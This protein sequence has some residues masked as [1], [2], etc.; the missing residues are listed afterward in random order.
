MPK[1]MRSI[2][3][4]SLLAFA[5]VMSLAAGAHARNA[6]DLVLYRFA[7]GS[8]AAQPE[9]GLI[10]DAAGN[11][12]GTTSAGGGIG[13]GGSGCGTV[14]QLSPQ[15]GGGWI[16]TILHTFQGGT[17]GADPDAP[18]VADADGNLYGS[19]SLGGS[20]NCGSG[21]GCGTVFR[22]TLRKGAWTE[23][24][25]YSF[26][27]KSR[28]S[29]GANSRGPEIV[30]P[31]VWAP[32][33]VAFGNDGN[34]YGF[35]SL[36]GRCD[37][38]GFLESCYGGAFKLRKPSRSRGAWHESVIYRARNAL[39][40]GP[41]GPPIFDSS[42]HLYGLAVS[43]NYGRVF[44]LQP[45]SGKGMWTASTLYTFEGGSD[46]GYPA[47]GLVFDARGNLYGATA[48]YRSLAGNVF[49]LTPEQ[50]ARWHETPLFTFANATD[51]STPAAAPIL[52]AN[53]DI[54]G[55]TE[56]G[57]QNNLGVAYELA[58]Q[59][60]GWSE[61]VLYS[62]AGGSDGA[63]PEGSLLAA[64]GTLYGVTLAGGNGGCFDDAG[65]GTVFAVA[66]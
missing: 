49:E 43:G 24:V 12:Y 59:N 23:A 47:P 1:A 58:A 56:A 32:N 54:Y 66:P 7:G 61:T 25:L 53:G 22:L 26:T 44:A 45:P 5:A 9:A 41:E 51:G 33:G 4:G 13:C 48:G 30:K 29:R 37:V 38:M 35:A 34:L 63:T 42:G 11:L 50:P 28:S 15:Q 3:R 27:T 46:G 14:F 40:S 36:G 21:S 19:T 65:C 17:D 8:D 20:D 62:F 31:D 60:G 16:E 2:G 39:A 18:L 10:A 55:L 57:G 52:A 64:D 6:Q